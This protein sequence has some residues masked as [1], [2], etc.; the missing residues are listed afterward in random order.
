[1]TDELVLLAEADVLF[2]SD[3]NSGYV[4]FAQA[5]YELVRG[6]HLMATGEVLDRGYDRLIGGP[7]TTGN[8]KPQFGVWGT[9]DWFFLPHCEFRADA[10]SRQQDDFT[11]LGQ[12]HVF[13]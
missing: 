1:M 10:Y 13:L 8:G 11:I 6:L 3:H 7:K 2:T 5:D 4:G 9:V 12:L